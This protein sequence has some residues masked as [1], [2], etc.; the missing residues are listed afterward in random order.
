MAQQ[1]IFEE[2]V[3]S[4]AGEVGYSTH[5]NCFCKWFGPGCEELTKGWK[6]RND[7]VLKG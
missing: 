1:G 4:A 2:K 6:E 7:R 5:W 3:G